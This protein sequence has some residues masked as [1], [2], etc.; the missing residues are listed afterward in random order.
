MIPE[1]IVAIGMSHFL[2]Q[3]SLA[4]RIAILPRTT[5]RT[6]LLE[7]L[8][9]VTRLRRSTIVIKSSNGSDG[10]D[11]KFWQ[12][13]RCRGSKKG[14]V[15]QAMNDETCLKQAGN[16]FGLSGNGKRG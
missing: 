9:D 13:K 14:T 5:L 15:I 7:M 1:L 4:W 8:V 3:Q 12:F 6:R 16:D 10:I 2:W 11:K